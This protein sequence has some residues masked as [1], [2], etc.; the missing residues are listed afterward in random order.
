M[1]TLINALYIKK[2]ILY[3]SQGVSACCPQSCFSAYYEYKSSYQITMTQGNNE[4]TSEMSFE[5]LIYW[6]EENW[7]DTKALNYYVSVGQFN[8]QLN[9][10]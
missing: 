4:R 6:A 1:L 5:A 2:T 10:A 3:F 9:V 7:T 8:S